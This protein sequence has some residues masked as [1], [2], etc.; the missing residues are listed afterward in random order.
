MSALDYFLS[1]AEDDNH[2]ALVPPLQ[3][4]PRPAPAFA[5]EQPVAVEQPE[6]T[7][8]TQRKALLPQ[9]EVLDEPSRGDEAL[10]ETSIDDGK[11]KVACMD[12]VPFAYSCNAEDRSEH[13]GTKHNCEN[14]REG[15][16]DDA[17]ILE[18]LSLIHI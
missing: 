15:A 14:T 11:T 10:N 6:L 18:Y 17:T 8:L 7:S 5:V 9:P 16:L 13:V 1:T 4:L 12:G 2:T 3:L